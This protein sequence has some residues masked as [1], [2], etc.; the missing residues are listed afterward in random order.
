M[1]EDLLERGTFCSSLAKAIRG[2]KGEE[3]LVIGLYGPWGSGKSSVKNIVVSLLQQS[4]PKVPVVEFNPWSWSGEDR[5]VSAFFEE[6]GAAL[7]ALDYGGDHEALSKKWKAY[8]ARMTLGG[9]SLGH[10]K[11][12]SEVA[13]IPW[14]PMILGTLSAAADSGSKLAEQAA[15]AHEVTDDTPAQKLK[16]Q[17]SVELKKLKSPVLVVMDDIDRLTTEE[18]RLLFRIVKA[19]ADFPNLVFVML[20]DRAIVEQSLEGH[21]GSSGRDYMAKIV[22]AGFD[23]ARPDQECLDSVL[24]RGLNTIIDS[25]STRMKF[26][27]DRWQQVYRDGLRPFFATLRDVRRFLSSFAFHVGLFFKEN[28]LEVNII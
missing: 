4:E 11:T 23:V 22:Q 16:E 1:D 5:L 10:L 20:Y 3:S 27:S 2:W 12:A 7:P 19:N 13:G 8:A 28:Q 9:T 24:F 6:L 14:V 26:N 25:D 18:I 17:L 21:V 15:K